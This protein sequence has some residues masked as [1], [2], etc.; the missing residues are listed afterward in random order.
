MR[1]T[2]T[3]RTASTTATTPLMIVDPI[4]QATADRSVRR[5]VLVSQNTAARFSAPPVRPSQL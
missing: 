1:Q 2:P 5:D 4:Q 3:R